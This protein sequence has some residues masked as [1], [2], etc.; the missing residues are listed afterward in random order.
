MGLF[1]A[2]SFGLLAGIVV[3]DSLIRSQE[4]SMDSMWLDK[5]Y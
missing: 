3:A 2:V 5:Y 1:L 4:R